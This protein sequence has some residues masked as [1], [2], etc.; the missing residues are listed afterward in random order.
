MGFME[1]FFGGTSRS[2]EDYV[3][4]D[5]DDITTNGEASMQVYIAE[6]GD[7]EDALAIKDAVYDGDIVVAD[8]T[9]HSTSDSTVEH[10][11]DELRQVARE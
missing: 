3:E 10:V 5:F 1:R 4:V 11:I 8:I 6:V 9:R 2:T 7:T